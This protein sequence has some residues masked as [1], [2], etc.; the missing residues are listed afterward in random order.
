MLESSLG[1]ELLEEQ[2]AEAL[3][4]ASAFRRLIARHNNALRDG[5]ALGPIER[6]EELCKLVFIA[7]LK[8]EGRALDIG[9]RELATAANG[10]EDSYGRLTLESPL[11]EELVTEIQ[12]SLSHSHSRVG[13]DFFGTAFEDLVHETL[14]KTQHQQYLTPLPIVE[15][16]ARLFP[17]RTGARIL[18][19][20]CGSSGFL[21]H[22]AEMAS[23]TDLAG[24]EID[25]R[26][27]WLSRLAMRI[28]RA[29]NSR[30]EL[31]GP[32]GALR[33]HGQL[34]DARESFDLILTNPPFGSD[35]AD[36]TEIV[37][38]ESAAGRSSIRRGVAFLEVCLDMLKPAG[39]AAV[40]IDDNVL[41]GVQNLAVRKMILRRARV[42]GIVSLPPET[43]MPYAS[44]SASILI[45]RKK[46]AKPGDVFLAAARFVGRRPNGE[47]L[48]EG[49]GLRPVLKS[50]LPAILRDWR[51]PRDQ[52]PQLAIRLPYSR[53]ASNPEL[54]FDYRFHQRPDLDF[55][56]VALG[57]LVQE[58]GEALV[59][60]R[61]KADAEWKF[62]GLRN[63]RPSGLGFSVSQV[64][65]SQIRSTVTRV[66]NGDF[67][68]SLMRPE[69]RKMAFVKD[70]DSR[71]VVSGECAVFRI[72]DN[73]EVAED[74]LLAALASDF[75]FQQIAH[76]VTGTGRPRVS[77]SALWEVKIPLRSRYSQSRIAKT[78][79]RH[80]RQFRRSEEDVLETKMRMDALLAEARLAFPS[81]AVPT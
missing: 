53:L 71:T 60:A 28:R 21:Q 27:V 26:M 75:V 15:F 77:R 39:F 48:L 49:R 43:F 9:L 8:H 67:L 40:I 50:D 19:P 63:L 17:V 4:Q 42:L 64:R 46:P 1:L 76:R 69:L 74:Y 25:P 44:V 57:D 3:S 13:P 38:F 80:L 52:R 45:L 72:K 20:A 18:D 55:G 35:F 23:N 68:F 36:P 81:D 65:G 30:I 16:M 54:R 7:S 58:S 47:P 2:S 61:A 6:F 73:S 5:T 22:V 56:G 29:K 37:A 32:P 14:E 66:T 51:Q 10:L 62:I 41:A 33:K 24:Y 79:L 34:P 59:P 11:A 31:L 12:G 78:F 70:A